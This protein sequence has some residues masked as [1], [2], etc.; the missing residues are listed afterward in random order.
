MTNVSLD[1][2]HGGL[3]LPSLFVD[4]RRWPFVERLPS[5]PFR[6]SGSGFKCNDLGID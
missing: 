3:W 2:R 4:L 1:L 6:L 5:L